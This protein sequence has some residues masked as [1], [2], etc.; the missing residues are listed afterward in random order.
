[1]RN[2]PASGGDTTLVRAVVA[3][4]HTMGLRVVVEGVETREQLQFLRE[5]QC[6]CYQGWLFAKALAPDDVALLYAAGADVAAEGA[7]G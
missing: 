3:L 4:A 1:M 5:M 6:A 7:L 2:V